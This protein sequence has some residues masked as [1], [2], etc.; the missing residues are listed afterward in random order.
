[1]LEAINS[2]KMD[3]TL[4]QPVILAFTLAGVLGEPIKELFVIIDYNPVE[5]PNANTIAALEMLFASFYA[6]N[7]KY[8]PSLNPVFAFLELLFKVKPTL[9]SSTTVADLYARISQ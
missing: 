7:L 9:K 6:F 8:P 1:M 5:I 4:T 3:K 2:I